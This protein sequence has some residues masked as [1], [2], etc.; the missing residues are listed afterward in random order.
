MPTKE[1]EK[2][3]PA[4]GKAGYSSTQI[5]LHWLIAALVLFQLLFGESMGAVMA[6]AERGR[7]LSDSDAT[8]G[9]LH[10]WAGLAILA[11]VAMRIV[12]RLSAGAP[13]ASDATPGWMARAARLSHGLFYALLVASPVLGLLAY[14]FGD[15]FGD[16]HS[17]SKPVF[18]VLIAIHAS[19]ALVH[20]FWL[21][22]DTLRRMIRPA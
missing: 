1:T 4:P 20:Q 5:A 21:R 22:D 11:L 13:S 2:L 6:A 14:Y 10:Y 15:P 8:L 17:L 3:M 16:I 19:A 12:V 9:N 18:I 7:P